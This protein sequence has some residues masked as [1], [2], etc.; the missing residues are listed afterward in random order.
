MH[1]LSV[2]G[3]ILEIVLRHARIHGLRDVKKISLEIGAL[4]DLE[5]E[6]IQRYFKTLAEGT[7]AAGAKIEV[8]KLPCRFTCNACF[9]GF[10]SDLTTDSPVTCPR[11]GSV[12]VHMIS[13]G[14]YTVKS[15]EGI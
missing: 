15:M 12:S 9:S 11:C 10:Q 5:E 7:A 1:E 2:T 13:G 6:W 4:S 14:E 8:T 3:D